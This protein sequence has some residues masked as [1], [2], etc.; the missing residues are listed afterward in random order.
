MKS[1]KADFKA[2][3]LYAVMIASFILIAMNIIFLE[4]FDAGFWL[5]ILSST[6]LMIAMLI[7]IFNYNKA[8]KQGKSGA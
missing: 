3:A 4:Q 7:S 8:K 5:R 2:I 1:K 6:L